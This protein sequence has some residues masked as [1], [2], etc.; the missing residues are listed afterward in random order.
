[1]WPYLAARPRHGE[2]RIQ[3]LQGPAIFGI[4][5]RLQNWLFYQ[6]WRHNAE[7]IK[8]GMSKEERFQALSQIAQYQRRVL[9]ESEEIKKLPLPNET[10]E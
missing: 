4:M 9:A 1:M 8:S 7:L 2:M 5:R 10:D 3:T 6:I